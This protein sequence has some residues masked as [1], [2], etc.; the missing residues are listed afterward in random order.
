VRRRALELARE[1][2]RLEKFAIPPGCHQFFD[3]V[4]TGLPKQAEL[5]GDY[6]GFAT[7]LRGFAA[8]LLREM[9]VRRRR[10]ERLDDSLACDFVAAY[11]DP[12]LHREQHWGSLS[13]KALLLS[14]AFAAA[15]SNRSFTRGSLD[16]FLERNK[17]LLDDARGRLVFIRSLSR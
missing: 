17:S 10:F 14:A 9:R 4:V 12:D 16:K 2:A 6:R 7:Q 11:E 8:F 15:G 5:Q 13:E 1:V 3:S